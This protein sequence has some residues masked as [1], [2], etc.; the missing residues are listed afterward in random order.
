MLIFTDGPAAWN[1]TT[2]SRIEIPSN[3]LRRSFGTIRLVLIVADRHL[4]FTR[5]DRNRN[6]R[7]PATGAS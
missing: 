2:V 5:E 6:G 7:K 1:L 3:F 4:V